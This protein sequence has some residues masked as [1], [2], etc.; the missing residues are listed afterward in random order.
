MLRTF[1]EQVCFVRRT[2]ENPLSAK[3]REGRSEATRPAVDRSTDTE[4]NPAD[5]PEAGAE[6]GHIALGHYGRADD[7]AATVAHLAGDGGGYITGASIAVD[8]GFAA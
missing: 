3:L 5:A 4:M 7:I 6:R 8:G 2:S 1:H